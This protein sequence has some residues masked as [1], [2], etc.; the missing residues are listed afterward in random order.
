M[1]DVWPRTSGSPAHG[2]RNRLGYEKRLTEASG[3][4]IFFTSPTAALS[5]CV[6]DAQ[7]WDLVGEVYLH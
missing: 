3:M 5:G 6:V 1:H 4:G 2:W 7:E